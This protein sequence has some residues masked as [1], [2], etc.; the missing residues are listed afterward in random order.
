MVDPLDLFVHEFRKK[1]EAGEESTITIT[2]EG[3]KA[4]NGQQLNS[5]GDDN[6]YFI[7][8]KMNVVCVLLN[9]INF[10][11]SGTNAVQLHG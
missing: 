9:R 1:G 8:C 4:E 3:Y 10:V 6:T 5:T 2:V 11:E 7:C